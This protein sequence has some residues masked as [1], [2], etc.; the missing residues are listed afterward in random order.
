[1]VLLAAAAGRNRLRHRIEAHIPV[2][3]GKRRRGAAGPGLGA[4]ILRATEA[5]FGSLRQFRSLERLLERAD[6]PLRASEFLWLQVGFGVVAGLL[7]AVAGSPPLLTLAGMAAGGAAPLGFARFRAGRR[8]KA[9][10]NQLPDLLITIAASL[11]AGHSFRQGIQTVVEE[12]RPPASDEFKRVLTE[13]SLGRPI[14]DALRDMSDRVGSANLEFVITA[15]TIQRQVGGSLAGLFDMVADAV[16]QRQQF[17][18]KIRGLTAMGRMS[19]YVLMGLPL[20]IAAVTTLMNR[21]YMSPLYS[22]STGH[23]L[24]VLGLMMMLVGS[25]LLKKVV[26]FK[27]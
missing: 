21:S 10:E 12:G 18:R 9:L 24:I 5:A 14:D 2:Q 23:K 16:R 8:L 13:T 26:S 4:R 6:L 22:T 20:F 17:A 1:V 19:A 27:G 15:V 25:A 3:G 7:F 11:K